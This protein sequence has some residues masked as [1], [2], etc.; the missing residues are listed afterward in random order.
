MS[1][2]NKAE[3]ANSNNDNT[4]NIISGVRN[5]SQVG[6]DLKS[7]FDEIYCDVKMR[8]HVG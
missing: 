6:C 3:R 5:S 4:F 2:T 1:H 8:Q 7:C